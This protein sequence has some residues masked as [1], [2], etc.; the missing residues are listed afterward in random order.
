ME[1]TINGNAM[2]TRIAVRIRSALSSAGRAQ[3]LLL[4]RQV[5]SRRKRN[6]A[7]AH[8]ATDGGDKQQ[9]AMA[10]RIVVRIR[11]ALSSAG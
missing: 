7:S 5:C 9:S 6:P 11:S 8:E 2:A 3:D 1:E 4:L 10:I